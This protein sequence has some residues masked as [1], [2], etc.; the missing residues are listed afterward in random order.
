MK[1]LIRD[2]RAECLLNENHLKAVKNRPPAVHSYK[3]FHQPDLKS[4]EFTESHHLSFNHE[5]NGEVHPRT[6]HQLNKLQ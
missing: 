5:T 1:F 6:D 4:S 2:N 3:D